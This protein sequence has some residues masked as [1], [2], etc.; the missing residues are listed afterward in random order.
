M[1]TFSM[2]QSITAQGQTIRLDNQS[3]LELVGHGAMALV[4][5]GLGIAAGKDVIRDI[6]NQTISIKGLA[7]GDA[8]EYGMIALVGVVYSILGYTLCKSVENIKKQFAK[9]SQ[10][11]Q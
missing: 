7:A 2:A 8:K 5:V 1:C 10:I 3:K 11:K 9:K 6:S 4:S